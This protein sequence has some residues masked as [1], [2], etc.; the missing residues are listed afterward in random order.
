VTEKFV[1]YYRLLEALGKPGCPICRCLLED[2]R[3]HLDALLYE[4][5]TDVEA[6]RRLRA[7][8]GLCN[9]HTWMLPTLGSGMTGAAILHEDLV[10]VGARRLDT[11]RDRRQSRVGRW[12]RRWP[13]GSARPRPVERHVRRARCP[14]CVAGRQ[15]EARYL[16]A[17]VEFLGDRE[18]ADAYTRSTG[19]CL[20][21]VV[22]AIEEGAEGDGLRRL[23]DETLPKWHD[24]GRR[25]D[26]F[27]RKHE[28]RNTQPMSAAESS[29][30]TTAFEIVAGAAGVFGND[31]HAGDGGQ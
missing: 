15:G 17:V 28:H 1:G 6:R 19:L 13:V 22:R 8:W 4:H 27:V 9:W 26:G 7:A 2:G 29:A 25:L 24:V 10:R 20:P 16:E 11:L 21:H 30:C 5:V 3:R 18:L 14:V 23:L 12:L 31:L